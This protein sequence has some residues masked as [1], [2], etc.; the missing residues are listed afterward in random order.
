MLQAISSRNLVH[1]F[2]L[3]AAR[4]AAGEEMLVT[5]RGKPLLKLVAVE[6][7]KMSA[8]ER[9]ALVQDLLNFRLA[10][11]Y[12]KSFERNDAYGE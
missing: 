3:I 7:A 11:P 9:E 8:N 2:S 1:N 12:G 5:K 4:V 10:Q 6:P